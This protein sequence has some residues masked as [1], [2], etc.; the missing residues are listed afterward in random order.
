MKDVTKTN[1]PLKLK[2][3]PKKKEPDYSKSKPVRIDVALEQTRLLA[4][5]LVMYYH[6]AWHDAQY[7]EWYYET[8][9]ADANW[10]TEIQG[11]ADNI[12]DWIVNTLKWTREE[13]LD[14]MELSA[15]YS[16]TYKSVSGQIVTV[17]DL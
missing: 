9:W 4:H 10:S 8:C 13:D 3:W 14:E 16:R 12:F 6:V 17:P 7:D 5:G 15:V 1:R 11:L 2:K